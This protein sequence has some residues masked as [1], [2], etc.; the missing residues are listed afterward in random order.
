MGSSSGRQVPLSPEERLLLACARVHPDDPA[1]REIDEVVRAGVNWEAVLERSNREGISSL[2]YAHL[3]GLPSAAS[4]MPA[5]IL[6]ELQGI[7]QGNWARNSVLTEA[8]S[9]VMALFE[10]AGIQAI[11]HKGMALIH[12]VYPDK[13][14]RPMA[15]IDLLVRPADLPA[16]RRT[17]QAAGFRT[18]GEALEAEEAFRGYLHFVRDSTVI[19]LHW[20]IAHYTRFDGIVRVDHAGIWRRALPLAVGRTRGLTLCP[21]DMLLHLALHLTLGSE[22]GRL[23]WF[24]DID[25]VLRRSAGDL[26]WERLLEE[27][28]RWRLSTILAYTLLVA[29]DSFGS[30]LPS[31]V[32]PRLLPGRLRQAALG[33]VMDAGH[34]WSLRGHPDDI[35]G[36]L[37]ETLL[38][39]RLRDMLR[40][41]G[42]SL[43]PCRSWLKFHY[44]LTS[45]WQVSL[46]RVLHPLRVCY[47]AAKHLH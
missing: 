6:S 40:V 2:V 11:T 28:T 47:L 34:P 24:S 32:V 14:L 22:F 38:M 43:F 29:R 35:K 16:V 19:D 44:S 26:N 17:L 4:R 42:K 13:G 15:D 27:A 5:A 21:E 31:A 12:L 8:W 23:I 45:W 36:Y 39:D 7:S 33:T 41:L 1:R 9:E 20:E 30:P 18:P 3:Q 10:G 25:A 37:A 46:H